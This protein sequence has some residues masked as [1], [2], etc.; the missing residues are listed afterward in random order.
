MYSSKD[1][2][3][4]FSSI[5]FGN[6]IGSSGSLLDSIKDQLKISNV[7]N[8]TDKNMKRYFM[9]ISD[10]VS[11]V[12]ISTK[13]SKSG[14]CHI[15]KMGE[16]VKILDIVE[17]IIKQH[18]LENQEHSKVKINFTGIRPGEK[19]EEKLFYEDKIEKTENKFILN[20]NRLLAKNS[21]P[22]EDFIRKIQDPKLE[23]SEFKNE[24]LK[25]IN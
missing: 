7:I 1:N 2:K 13:I 22:I 9:T 19:I 4:H 3:C 18:N 23:K 8:V 11:L 10:A 15:L 24:L 20:E 6:V 14:D 5:R 16:K 21:I 12:L 17:D 25:F